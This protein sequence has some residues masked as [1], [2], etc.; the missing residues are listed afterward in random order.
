MPQQP[1]QLLQHCSLQDPN[2]G[3]RDF[4][5]VASLVT[6]WQ[7]GPWGLR[8]DLS[9][10]KGYGDQSDVWGFVAMPYYD[11][12]PRTQ[13]VFRYTYLSSDESNGLRLSR[14][15][16]RVVDG[17]GDEYKEVFGGFNFFFYDHKLKWQTGLSHA[18]MTD[19]ADD[20]GQ[21]SGWALSTVLRVYWLRAPSTARIGAG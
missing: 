4:S 18:S 16:D 7:S 21:H 13:L 3:T 10:G 2:N 12:S 8:T 20:G 15:E 11:L 17:R 5:Q 9:S 14:Y 19:R 6:E 1:M